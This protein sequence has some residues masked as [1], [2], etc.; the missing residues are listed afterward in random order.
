MLDKQSLKDAHQQSASS[1]TPRRARHIDCER[2]HPVGDTYAHSRSTLRR[3]APQGGSTYS[4][5]ERLI[6]EEL[7]HITL[8]SKIARR[9]VADLLACA[10]VA[11]CEARRRFDPTLGVSFSAYAR[12]RVR[13]AIYDGLAEVMSPFGRRGS[14][15]I[16][17]ARR[18]HVQRQLEDTREALSASSAEQI[19]ETR[20]ESLPLHKVSYAEVY[21]QLQNIHLRCSERK[22][23]QTDPLLDAQEREHRQLMREVL[24]EVFE[25][26]SET[27]RELIT[28]VYDLREIG[29]SASSYARRKR[30]HR[31]TIT[32]QHTLILL[33]LKREARRVLV[34]RS[35]SSLMTT[36]D[37]QSELSGSRTTARGMRER[38][39]A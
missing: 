23:A 7:R 19:C 26:L 28:A 12:Q 3:D 22:Y 20:L 11:I 36:S 37:A 1:L 13:G 6:Y 16:L 8:N 18:R 29:D 30:V 38:G 34:S 10:W 15:L 31:S 33:K 32:R 39:G 27:E 17:R 24:S 9:E 21:E 25:T 35:L 14:K 5:D 4:Y 2:H